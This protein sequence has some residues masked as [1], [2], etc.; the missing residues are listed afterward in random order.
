MELL[1][2]PQTHDKKSIRFKNSCFKG[3]LEV[4]K[5]VN[6]VTKIAYEQIEIA[7]KK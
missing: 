1:P 7:M 2:S 3:V 4:N 6:K 5:D